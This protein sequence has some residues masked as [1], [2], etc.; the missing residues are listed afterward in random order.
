VLTRRFDQARPF[1]TLGLLVL[2][3]LLIPTAVKRFTRLSF[4]ELQAPME[5]VPSYVRDL[6][7]FWSLRTRSKTD[8][9]EAGRDLARLTASYEVQAAENV[10]LQS[11][12]KRLEDL[13]GLP[14][15]TEYRS[16]AARVVRRDFNAWWQRLVIRKGRNFGITTGSPVIFS[17]GVVGRVTEVG[18]YTAIVDLVSS[19]TMRLAASLEGDPRPISFQG[20]VAHAFS[21]PRGRAEYVPLDIVA[22]ETSPRRLV[23]SG[24]GGL[25]PAGL[26]IGTLVKLEDSTDGLFRSG[27]VVLDPRLSELLEVTVLVPLNPPAALADAPR[28]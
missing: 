9:I 24:L 21:Q 25:F 20:G 13:L 1:V 15:D 3:W 28:S 5:V 23:T 11:E 19:P 17:G 26:V 27:E 18:A 7:D 16:E 2:A 12:I 14:T 8:L 22:T 6:Q 10:A 4:F